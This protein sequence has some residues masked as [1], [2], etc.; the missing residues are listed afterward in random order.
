MPSLLHATI[1]VGLSIAACAVSP[2]APARVQLRA[3]ALAGQNLVGV[4]QGTL[5]D[6]RSLRMVFEISRAEDGSLRG[7]LHR[8]DQEPQPIA[9]SEIAL[10]GSEVKFT[11]PGIGRSYEGTLTADYNSIN[12]TW[13]QGPTASSLNLVRAT[14]ETAWAIPV[15]PA[16]AVP[17]APDINPSFEVA[18]IKLSPSGPRNKGIRIVGHQLIGTSEAVKDLVNFS[19]GLDDQQ[20]SGAPPWYSSELFDIQ[21]QPNGDGQP[22]YRQWQLMMQ[23][24]LADRFK[25]TFHWTKQNLAAYELT[26]ANGGPK[27]TPSA[28]DPTGFPGIGARLGSV[29][30]RNASMADFAW[31]MQGGVDRP[32]LDQTGLQG[33]Y[34]FTLNWTPDEFQFSQHG[35][36]PPPPVPDNAPPDLYTA[37]REQLGLR[38]EAAKAPIPVLVIDHVEEPSPN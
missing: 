19:Y 20:I 14:S 15:P 3:P 37:I 29:V 36:T 27:L 26:V 8:I 34:D 21:A 4:W 22:N 30:A 16:R 6:G 13:T 31:I 32:V 1:V 9:I 11:A 33:K 7:L 12:G 25:L 24:L 23:K 10:T 5:A 35:I 38:F 17:M 2:C 18:S 28:D